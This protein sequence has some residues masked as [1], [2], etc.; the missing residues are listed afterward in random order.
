MAQEC[1]GLRWVAFELLCTRYAKD[2]Q[3]ADADRELV[4]H[5]DE[6]RRQL[7]LGCGGSDRRLSHPVPRRGP[8]A[9][10]AP[11][12]NARVGLFIRIGGGGKM[13]RKVL[14]TTL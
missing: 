4:L 3:P 7:G 2:V 6:D 5:P 9:L 8:T 11:D 12:P 10:D 1:G 14:Q 13:R